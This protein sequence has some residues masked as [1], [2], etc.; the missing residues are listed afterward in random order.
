MKTLSE[1]RTNMLTNYSAES[2]GKMINYIAETDE[3]CEM[4]E[5]LKDYIKAE[6]YEAMQE[7]LKKA[8]EFS[9]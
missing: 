1:Y 7:A 5:H 4:L 3:E 9:K 8:M 2:S 6:M